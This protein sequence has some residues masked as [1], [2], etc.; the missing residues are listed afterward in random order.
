ME[1]DYLEL[2]QFPYKTHQSPYNSYPSPLRTSR[3]LTNYNP[4]THENQLEVSGFVC[5]IGLVSWMHN[6]FKDK[7]N[8]NP[9]LTPK[10]WNKLKA[11][12]NHS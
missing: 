10:Q 4:P 3:F 11:K 9:I 6:P 12:N 1:C 5:F 2:S 8:K 7:Y